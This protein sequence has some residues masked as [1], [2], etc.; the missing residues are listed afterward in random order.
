MASRYVARL[1]DLDLEKIRKRMTSM[2]VKRNRMGFSL[3]VQEGST[4][5]EEEW[6]LN[7][8]T[9]FLSDL[10]GFPSTLEVHAPQEK[11]VRWA[12]RNL[13]LEHMLDEVENEPYP[14][15][16]LDEFESL[17]V[18][19]RSKQKFLSKEE[20]P[21]IAEA[22]SMWARRL[23]FDD[24][25]VRYAVTIYNP[26]AEHYARHPV[27]RVKVIGGDGNVL[28][29]EDCELT[30]LPPDDEIAWAGSLIV[31]APPK[32]IEVSCEVPEWFSAAAQSQ[33]IPEFTIGDVYFREKGDGSNVVVA[34]IENPYDHH[35]DDI[36]VTALFYGDEDELI[37]GET[38]IF[39]GLSP[40]EMKSFELPVTADDLKSV[41][42]FVRPWTCS[43]GCPFEEV[44]DGY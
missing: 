4:S 17:P 25:L 22:V 29:V 15:D 41:S 24:Y 14:E 35:F 16:A 23:A 8:I 36:A 33:D 11:L 18:Q 30:L 38:E 42:L 39:P 12:V 28:G 43:P 44:L 27:L 40:F 6:E 1:F 26:N 21:E 20:L 13:G 9:F 3:N 31:D 34:E 7:E 2:G 10:K 37:G 19:A 32:R 5:K